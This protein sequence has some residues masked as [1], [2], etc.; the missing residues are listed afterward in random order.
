MLPAHCPLRD[1]A[2]LPPA[3]TVATM[4]ALERCAVCDAWFDP[5]ALDELLFHAVGSCMNPD[6]ERPRT[7]IRGEVADEPPQA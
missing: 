3:R 1:S 6:A 5:L 4:P 2:P 7:G